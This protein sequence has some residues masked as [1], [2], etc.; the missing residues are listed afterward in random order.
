MFLTRDSALW[1]A[2]SIAAQH[3]YKLCY[4]G[5]YMFLCVCVCP[6][7]STCA[8]PGVCVLT[9]CVRALGRECVCSQ[10]FSALLIMQSE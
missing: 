9:G 10:G 1:G 5:A 7:E 4:N 8:A 6:C 2:T 3:T